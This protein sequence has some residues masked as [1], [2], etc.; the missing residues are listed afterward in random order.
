MDKFNVRNVIQAITIAATALLEYEDDGA[1]YEKFEGD[2]TDPVIPTRTHTENNMVG[3]GKPF[4]KQ[5]KPLEFDPRNIPYNGLLTTHMGIRILRMFQGGSI[6]TT[7][8]S[9]PAT[10]DSLIHQKTS[11]ETPLMANMLRKLGGEQLVHGDTFVQTVNITQ[12]MKQ[13][14]RISSQLSNTGHL[15]KISTLGLDV[16]DIEDIPDY[17]TFDGNR[18]RVTF[19]DGTN[20]YDLIVLDVNFQGNQNVQVEGLPKDPYYDAAHPCYGSYAQNVMIGVQSANMTV[21]VYMDED[22]DVFDAWLANKKLTNVKLLFQTCEIIGSTTHHGEIEII[23]PIAEFTLSGG[24]NKDMSAFSFNIK[25]I[26]GDSVSGDLVQVRI[27]DT[28]A[29]S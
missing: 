2:A 26:E 10:V 21:K 14:P 23:F 12:S 28:V 17:L 7:T 16:A 27:R 29:I 13:Q 1:N 25:A 9:L 24:Q 18:T 5:S 22:F 15:A 11:G 3:D 20:N 8:N 6:A 4:P 19:T